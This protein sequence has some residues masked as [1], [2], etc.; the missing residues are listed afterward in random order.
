HPSPTTTPPMET[1][2][3]IHH[4]TTVN[5]IPSTDNLAKLKYSL[6][7]MSLCVYGVACVLGMLGNGAV[8][9][10]TGFR[11]KNTVNILWFLHLAVADFLFT[12][13]LPFVITYQALNYNWVLG[14]FMCK[15]NSTVNFLNLF[16]SV[17]TLVAISI[18]RF[19]LLVLPIW[20]QVHRSV[21]KAV[22]SYFVFR[23]TEDFQSNIIC[24]NNLALSN[25]YRVHLPP[26]SVI[27]TCYGII[28]H[29]LR[30]NPI[31]AKQSSRSFNIIAA[32]IIT[33]FLCWVP[34]HIFSIIELLR[35]HPNNQ[36]NALLHVITIGM[37]FTTSLAFVNSC[38]NP[39]LYVFMG[40]DFKDKVCS[41]ILKV[42]ETAFHEEDTKTHTKSVCTSK[43]NKSDQGTAV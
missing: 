22:L 1:N 38:L 37:P 9:W 42:L 6:H 35:F 21:R 36:G 29:R 15:L 26:Y 5:S 3:S 7:I 4:N 8:I 11:M 34:F 23:D 32:I 18:D 43:R 14:K 30:S 31:L 25:N 20:A 24:Y 27:I 16:A 2:T 13:F 10:A 40:Q 39:I 41:S 28:I 12:A 33:F 19:V 17:Y